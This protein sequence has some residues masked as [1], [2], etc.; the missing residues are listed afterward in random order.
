MKICFPDRIFLIRGN[1]ECRLLTSHFSFKREVIKKYKSEEL[2]DR[3]MESFD[4]LPLSLLIETKNARFL[5]LHGGLS[6]DLPTIES[7]QQIDRFR[8][9]GK[10]GPLCDILWSD[11]LEEDTAEGLSEDEMQEWFDVD[12]V[13]NPNRGC[14][15]V[16][17]YSAIQKFLND[18]NLTTL[19][20][21]HEVQ[22]TGYHLHHFNVKDTKNPFVVTIFSAPNYCDFYQNTAA[23][24]NILYDDINETAQID[25][26]QFEY[27]EHPFWLPNL[28]DGIEYTFPFLVEKIS[29]ICKYL[30]SDKDLGEETE[31]EKEFYNKLFEELKKVKSG[32]KSDMVITTPRKS[33]IKKTPSV[34]QYPKE[35]LTIKDRIKMLEQTVKES[36]SKKLVR[37]PSGVRHSL[38]ELKILRARRRDYLERANTPFDKARRADESNERIPDESD[39]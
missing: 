36:A 32:N 17:G 11:P 14:G 10:S 16:F 38:I 28:Q 35:F 25:F 37:T 18:N 1:H 9:P 23:F 2:Y 8:E 39:C 21:A 26:I 19:I 4:A 30:V 7:I 24:M 13:E 34:V 29:S 33:N 22:R 3:I 31:E 15:Y 20:R 5:C 27:V 6:P 12:Y